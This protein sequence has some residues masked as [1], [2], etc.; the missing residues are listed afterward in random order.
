M[1]DYNGW[2]V[3]QYHAEFAA[4]TALNES[5]ATENA[6]MKR[7]IEQQT[8]SINA[9][10]EAWR[11]VESQRQKVDWDLLKERDVNEAGSLAHKVAL[12]EA[13]IRNLRSITREV[14]R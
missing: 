14:V 11:T 5:Y 3:E 7:K 10:A 9:Y 13:E 2:K 1:S 6:M 12:L 8:D 4:L